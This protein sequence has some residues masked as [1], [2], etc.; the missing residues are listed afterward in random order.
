[1]RS[2]PPAVTAS[3]LVLLTSLPACTAQPPQT[4]QVAATRAA[5]PSVEEQFL[6]AT[7]DLVML[8]APEVMPAPERHE[9]VVA[10][11]LRAMLPAAPGGDP[12]PVAVAFAGGPVPHTPRRMTYVV[13]ETVQITGAGEITDG[14]IEVLDDTDPNE[15][16]FVVYRFAPD[17]SIRGQ[18]HTGRTFTVSWSAVGLSS[19]LLGRG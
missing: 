1:M 6:A 17:G 19:A 10:A 2:I 12:Q 5:V 7:A 9:K 16:T 13:L 14:A 18:D 3:A 11:T 8:D 15:R 4:P